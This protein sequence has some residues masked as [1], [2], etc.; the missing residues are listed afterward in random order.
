[1]LCSGK[2]MAG[3]KMHIL[4]QM[5]VYGFDDGAFDRTHIRDRGAGLQMRCNISGDLLH[6]AN[7]NRKDDQIRVFHSVCRALADAITQPDLA[8]GVTGLL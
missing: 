4:G 5:G 1:M 8:G 6:C 3:N 7:R 2:G